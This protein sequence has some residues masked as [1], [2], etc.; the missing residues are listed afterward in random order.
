MSPSLFSICKVLWCHILKNVTNNIVLV[1]KLRWFSNPN[2]KPCKLSKNFD[3]TSVLPRN[4]KPS[5]AQ[6]VFVGEHS[7]MSKI[8]ELM[9]LAPT[10]VF[11]CLANLDHRELQCGSSNKKSVASS[12]AHKTG[13]DHLIS[14]QLDFFGW[15]WLILGQ[16]IPIHKLHR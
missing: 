16:I 1:N 10:T 7:V 13:F 6:F 9:L 11:A 8:T 5:R 2:S 14:I 3:N 12:T 15:R 4:S